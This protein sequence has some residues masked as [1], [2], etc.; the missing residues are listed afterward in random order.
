MQAFA[1]RRAGQAERT[2]RED[3]FRNIAASVKADGQRFAGYLCAHLAHAAR[4][5]QKRLRN[6]QIIV[7]GFI[8]PDSFAF[9]CCRAGCLRPVDAG[10]DLADLFLTFGITGCEAD[11]AVFQNQPAERHGLQLL[12]ALL[13]A[14]RFTGCHIARL[15][16]GKAKTAGR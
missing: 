5:Q 11:T 12:V 10:I 15:P 13:I 6:I 4:Q 3:V 7:H 8:M 14:V 2:F 1:E 9:D 16:D